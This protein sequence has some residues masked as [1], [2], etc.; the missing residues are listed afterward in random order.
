VHS[1]VIPRFLS[2]LKD[3]RVAASKVFQDIGL[4]E[5]LPHPSVDKKQLIDDVRKVLQYSKIEYM[6]GQCSTPQ[7]VTAQHGTARHCAVWYEEA[8]SQAGS[9]S[10]RE[11]LLYTVPWL[12]AGPVRIQDLQL[13]PGHEPH[14]RQEPGAGLGSQPGGAGTHLEGRLHHSRQIPRP[15]QEGSLPFLAVPLTVV[16]LNWCL[17]WCLQYSSNGCQEGFGWALHIQYGTSRSAGFGRVKL[18]W[19]SVCMMM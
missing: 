18:H 1:G 6:T 11:A 2:G 17:Q 16:S 5:I 15:H 13:R 4:P 7:H 9:H 12:P 14:P 8:H 10:N 19:L 3:E